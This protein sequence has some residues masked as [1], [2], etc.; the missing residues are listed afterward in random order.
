[1][2]LFHTFPKYKCFG[3]WPIKFLLGR[4]LILARVYVHC[5]RRE[6]PE[7]QHDF[8]LHQVEWFFQNAQAMNSLY[9]PTYYVIAE[10]PLRMIRAGQ[11]GGCS[12]R[13]R[14]KSCWMH[15]AWL[16]PLPWTAVGRTSHANMKGVA[17]AA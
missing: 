1:M 12:V 16:P 9:D 14:R 6:K 5:S 4:S 3:N 15:F 2:K 13:R 8:V 17:G 11:Y 10:P 7:K